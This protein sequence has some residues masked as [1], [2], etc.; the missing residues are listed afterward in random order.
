LFIIA[1]TAERCTH[2]VAT[3]RRAAAL[4]SC[5]CVRLAQQQGAC[6]QLTTT[7]ATLTCVTFTRS[8]QFTR[9]HS[10]V[11]PPR[12]QRAASMRH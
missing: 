10:E 5:V 3:T 11:A 7:F 1:V 4:Q 6:L 8:Q 2:M 9:V 12:L